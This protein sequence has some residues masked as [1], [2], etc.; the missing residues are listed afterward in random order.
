MNEHVPSKS[1]TLPNRQIGRNRPIVG[2]VKNESPGTTW[3]IAPYGGT[4]PCFYTLQPTVP[5]PAIGSVGGLSGKDDGERHCSRFPTGPTAEIVD[6]VT[7][8]HNHHRRSR[9]PVPPQPPELMV[10]LANVERPKGGKEWWKPTTRQDGGRGGRRSGGPCQEDPELTLT[11]RTDA[12]KPGAPRTCCALTPGLILR[13][14]SRDGRIRTGDPLNPIQ[15]RYR[16]APRPVF[17]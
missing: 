11:C 5:F 12:A 1:P 7:R 13:K 17:W 2:V 9:A 10:K 15:V 14:A 16:A 3:L 8:S 4:A 6:A